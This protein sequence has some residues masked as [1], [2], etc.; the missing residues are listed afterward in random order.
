MG[1]RQGLRGSNERGWGRRGRE[2]EKK[3]ERERETERET[4][5]ERK[6]ETEKERKR[7]TE[8]EG[9]P[10]GSQIGPNKVQIFFYIF[11]AKPC[12]CHYIFPIKYCL[13]AFSPISKRFQCFFD[14]V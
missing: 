5:K 1:E 4:E 2:K 11:V 10:K 13:L 12:D 7:E 6:R 8:R 3:R 9:G 14:C